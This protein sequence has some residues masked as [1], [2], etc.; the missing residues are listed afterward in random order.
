MAI[1]P[2]LR[3]MK[4]LVWISLIWSAE[5]Y[6]QCMW[7]W[8]CVDVHR[9]YASV[10]L[11]S[12]V[13]CSVK[14][15]QNRSEEARKTKLPGKTVFHFDSRVFHKLYEKTNIG[16]RVFATWKQKIQWQN[17]IPSGDR[18]GVP[19]ISNSKSNTLLSKLVRH[20]LLRRSFKVPSMHH[21]FFG[22]RWFS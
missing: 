20:V 5:I 11:S 10:C 9:F 7:M 22:L 19:I 6:I 17:V 3:N 12:G 21:L 13:W 16:I 18:T 1:L 8:F 15:L 2:T 4:N 14:L